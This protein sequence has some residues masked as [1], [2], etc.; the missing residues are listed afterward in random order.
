MAPHAARDLVNGTA[1]EAAAQV[2][3]VVRLLREQ[4]NGRVVGVIRPFDAEAA[5]VFADGFDGAQEF[6]LLDGE[7]AHGEIDGRA[8]LQQHQ[9]FEERDGIF[10]AGYGY[11]YAV[12]IANHFETMNRFAD[13]AQQ[14]FFEV[15]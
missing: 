6:A 14:V 12:A 1:A 3:S 15:H 5:D 13:F 9:R 10:A 8:F 7:G 11:G 2:A 4:S